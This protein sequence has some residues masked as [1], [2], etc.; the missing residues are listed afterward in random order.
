VPKRGGSTQKLSMR[1]SLPPATAGGS[2][3]EESTITD[4]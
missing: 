4:L 1:C 3:L 2:G